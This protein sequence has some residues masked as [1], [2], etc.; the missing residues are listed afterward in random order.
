[1][2]VPLYFVGHDGPL[3]LL[4]VVMLH[5]KDL[6]Q[7]DMTRDPRRFRTHHALNSLQTRI[8]IMTQ[9]NIA[10]PAGET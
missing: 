6:G 9:F 2:V 8:L 3:F 4:K 1:M 10:I 7:A 5:L